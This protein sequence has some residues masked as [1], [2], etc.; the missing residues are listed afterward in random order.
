M[1]TRERIELQKARALEL[2]GQPE[3]G[4]TVQLL[5]TLDHALRLMLHNRAKLI[6]QLMNWPHYT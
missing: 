5:R 2:Q 3:C 1:E 4:T 6:R